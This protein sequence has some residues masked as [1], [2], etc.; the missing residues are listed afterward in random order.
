MMWMPTGIKTALKSTSKF[1]NDTSMWWR[2]ESTGCLSPRPGTAMLANT[3]LWQEGT[4][5]LLHSMSMVCG[6]IDVFCESS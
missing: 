6:D 5:V 2:E 4:G 1:K 3:P